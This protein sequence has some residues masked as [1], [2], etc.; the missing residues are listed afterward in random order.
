MNR[1]VLS[2]TVTLVVDTF[3]E[4]MARKIFWGL[5]GLSTAMIAFFLFI[6]KI[7]IVEGALATIS[8]FGE[9]AKEKVDLN[10]FVRQVEGAIATFLYTWGMFLAIFAS[11]GLTPSLLEPGRIELLLSKPVGRTQLL[12]GRYLGNLLIVGLNTAYLV[13][14]IWLLLG[15]KTAIWDPNFL[16]SIATTMF[17]FAVLLAVVVLVGVGFESTALAVMI[18][19]GLMLVSPILAQHQLAVR[20]L[21]SEWSRQVWKALYHVLPKVYDIGKMNLDYVRF[22]K[23]DSLEPVGS[24]AAFGCVALL[25]AI[26]WFRRRDF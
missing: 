14:G 26:Y 1:A 3:R 17:L 25:S 20:L 13:G 23:V 10:R 4:A 15:V 7:D 6:L 11:A 19:V 2:T 8:I 22:G 12:L 5:F 9:T 24:S 16:I 18:P 21:N